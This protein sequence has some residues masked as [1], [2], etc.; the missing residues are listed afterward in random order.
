MSAT[1]IALVSLTLPQDLVREIDEA[2]AETGR[3]REEFLRAAVRR[4]VFSERQWRD[5]QAYGAERAEA[6]GLRD[7]RDL[8]AFLDSLSDDE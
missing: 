7:E 3:T 6:L 8:Q 5:L 1:S 4:F 2:V